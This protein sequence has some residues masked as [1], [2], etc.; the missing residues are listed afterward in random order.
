ML[1]SFDELMDGS[2]AP[3]PEGTTLGFSREG[4]PVRGFVLGAG[5]RKV[6]LISGC[7]A[8]EPV[9]AVLLDRLVR[10][11]SRGT[12]NSALQSFQWWVVPDANPD[13]ADRNRVWSDSKADGAY[14]L[15]G[16]LRHAQREAPGDDV[17]FGFPRGDD[18]AGARPENRAV[19][20]WWRSDPRPFHL[21]AS[22][23]GMA[24]AAGP[25]YLIDRAWVDRCEL[26][27]DRCRRWTHRLGY[28][29]H[30]VERH[31]EKGF[32]RIE[33]GF[34][35]RPDSGAMADYFLGQ[36]DEATARLFRPSSMET[37]R[38][39][40]GDAL[41]LVSEIPLFT[42]PGVGETI[43]PVDEAA[44]V[45][46]AR[47]AEWKQRAVAGDALVEREAFDAGVE[48]VPILDQMRLQW[49]MIRAGVEQAA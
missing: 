14:S 43:E 5:S 19:Y 15:A 2:A 27:K 9:G 44:E 6:S 25:W 8:D 11:L 42:L 32:S 13:G 4:R 33:R 3:T 45:W 22:L 21:H 49:E 17:E 36:G 1:P 39:L 28:R 38:S 47:L 29:L 16:Y 7:H 23:H 48:A 41:T 30:D 37:I 35:T 40:G 34:C 24:F 10:F 26:V 31:G 20:D 18:D 12:G 46:R